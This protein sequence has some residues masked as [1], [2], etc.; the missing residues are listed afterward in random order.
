[1]VTWCFW[2]LG[3]PEFCLFRVTGCLWCTRLFLCLFRVTYLSRY[4]WARAVVWWSW[5]FSPSRTTSPLVTLCTLT[6]PCSVWQISEQRRWQRL[7]TRTFQNSS[8]PGQFKLI[9]LNRNGLGG[10]KC[11]RF[12][13][14]SKSSIQHQTIIYFS[15]NKQVILELAELLNADYNK[16]YT[17]TFT[18]SLGVCCIMRW[19]KVRDCV[20][21]F[22]QRHHRQREAVGGIVPAASDPYLCWV[23]PH[24]RVGVQGHTSS[25]WSTYGKWGIRW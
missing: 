2:C 13:L 10:L 19:V 24:G 21:F 9:L 14:S 3:L 18:F 6:W 20:Y 17:F 15:Y 12:A 25:Q 23:H 8:C 22:L 11:H 16:F 5:S 1:M 7:S 4:W